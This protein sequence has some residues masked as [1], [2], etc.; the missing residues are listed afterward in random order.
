MATRA[1]STLGASGLW[2]ILGNGRYVPRRVLD[3]HTENNSSSLAASSSSNQAAKIGPQIREECRAIHQGSN[4][5]DLS[6]CLD[7]AGM[8]AG[9][10]LAP[11]QRNVTSGNAASRKTRC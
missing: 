1:A 8:A 4:D 6:F 7:K 2:S 11:S 5:A 9:T 3:H 10:M